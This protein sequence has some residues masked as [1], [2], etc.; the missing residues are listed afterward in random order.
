MDL[1]GRFAVQPLNHIWAAQIPAPCRGGGAAEDACAGAA[2]LGHQ[3]KVREDGLDVLAAVF[4][5]ELGEPVLGDPHRE[6][7]R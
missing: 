5:H 1:M 6:E 3:V 4:G 7:P 2:P